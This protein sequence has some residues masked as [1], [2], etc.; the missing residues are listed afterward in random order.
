MI[1]SDD[2]RRACGTFDSAQCAA[3]LN[4]I[5]AAEAASSPF[6]LEE[7]V[8]Q[9][10]CLIQPRIKPENE[11]R[12]VQ[13]V[14]YCRTELAKSGDADLV[15]RFEQ[16]L[17]H[18]EL[19]ER[20]YRAILDSLKNSRAGQLPP[21]TQVWAAIGRAVREIVVLDEQIKKTASVHEGFFDPVGAK[22]KRDGAPDIDADFV[23][24]TVAN[25]LGST[26]MMLAYENGWIQ[27]K[28]LTLPDL[29]AADE[30][31]LLQAGSTAYLG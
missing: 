14:V 17:K 25:V 20:G 24:N 6:V 26:I 1:N 29:V 2:F 30:P 31:T 27:N 4:G 28:R 19:L 7:H 5:P 18:A 15:A 12:R 23:V 22:V 21:A 11:A 8:R 10:G 9:S 13:F 16:H 3:M